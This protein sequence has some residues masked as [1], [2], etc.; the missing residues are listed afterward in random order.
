MNMSDII[1][2]KITAALAPTE[3]DVVNE[4]HLHASHMD[5]SR[6]NTHFR[7]TIVAEKFEGL[8]PVQRHKLVYGI[9]SEEMPSTIHALA[10]HLKSPSEAS[11]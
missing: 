10:L 3:F 6:N 1:Q 7:L 9:L 4:S 8:R 2:Q 11:S 5:T